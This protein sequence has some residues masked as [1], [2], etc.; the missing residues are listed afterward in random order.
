[1]RQR[2][3][4]DN[5]DLHIGPGEGGLYPLSVHYSP[6]GETATPVQVSIAPEDEPMRRWLKRLDD[7]FTRRDD[8]IALGRSLTDVLLPPGAVRDLY[9]RSLGKS[10]AR[11]KGLRLRLRISPPE[12]AALPWEYAYDQGIGDFFALNPRTV[13]VR[14]HTQ[15]VPPQPVTSRTPVPILALISNP[16]DSLPLEAARETRVLVEA[17]S[18]L[19]DEGRVELGL[20]FS[21]SAQERRMIGTLVADQAGADLLPGPASVDALRDALRHGYRVLHYIG[22]GVFDEKRGGALLLTD[23]EGDGVHISA[24]TLARELRGTSVAVAVLNACQSA[25]QS[26]AR[27]FMG[28]APSLIRAG[29]PA[30]VAM[31]YAIS[32]G[33]ATVFSRALYKALAAGWPLDAGVTEGRKAISAE[34]TEDDM[35]WGIPV[36]F[37]RSEDGVLWKEVSA[38]RDEQTSSPE[39]QAG[40]GPR[41]S[42]RSGGVTFHGPASV[43][44][45]VVGRDKI[46]RD[47]HAGDDRPEP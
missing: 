10:E 14:Y 37:M 45:D 27:S 8:L 32:D 11:E 25:T 21:G 17:L 28:L 30:V 3:V 34:R 42:V 29:V 24:V 7:G 41:D 35:D 44:R 15:P 26:T 47:D 9:Q 22:H 39:V 31:Q 33:S 6:A 16:A 1:M 23:D 40:I 13:L 43:G 20:L 46:V 38:D 4:F 19:L 2:P 18:G 12:L 36:L 5:F